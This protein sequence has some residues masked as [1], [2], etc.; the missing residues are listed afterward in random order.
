M[1]TSVECECYSK[2]ATQWVGYNI[3]DGMRVYPY[4][5]VTQEC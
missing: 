1:T 2:V 3:G 5:Y 4:D